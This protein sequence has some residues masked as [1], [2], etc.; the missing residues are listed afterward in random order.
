M[1]KTN[2][3]LF[4]TLMCMVSFVCSCNS[5][6]VIENSASKRT[7]KVSDMGHVG[8]FH[9]E[10]MSYSANKISLDELTVSK[11][12][13][14]EDLENYVVNCW[15]KKLVKEVTSAE[16]IECLKENMNK[17]KSFLQG[18]KFL[19]R[20][21][22][23]ARTRASNEVEINNMVEME[24]IDL[25]ILPS[26]EGMALDIRTQ[27]IC[28]SIKCDYFD[29]IIELI[30]DGYNGTVSVDIYNER[31]NSIVEDFDNANFS[32]DDTEAQ[33]IASVL[34]VGTYSSE[35]W[36]EN[37][38]EIPVEILETGK[39][40]HVLAADLAGA[41]IG[42]VVNLGGQAFTST[43]NRFNW[44]SF[45][46]GVAMGAITGSTGLLGKIATCFYA[47]EN[48][49]KEQKWIDICPEEKP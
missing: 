26:L 9:N 49:V 43:S 8:E 39:M 48:P 33:M 15:N 41:L 37:P 10:M 13:T 23:N 4:S 27:G 12:E 11:F 21:V 45:G 46:W 29:K 42:G 47:I 20:C 22:T 24:E 38:D 17:F 32:P 3:L 7:L 25:N 6:D 30:S 14:A 18:E 40:P 5:N 31:L 35:W 2:L 44:K 28:S 34:S 19:D 16:D 36:S 1:D